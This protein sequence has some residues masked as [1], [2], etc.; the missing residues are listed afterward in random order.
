MPTAAKIGYYLRACAAL[1]RQPVNLQA[2]ARVAVG[3][4]AELR[5]PYDVRLTVLHPLDVLLA[6]ETVIDDHYG[7]RQLR[8]ARRIVDA[9]AGT[10][11]FSILAAKLFPA[12]E[13]VCFEP[14]PRYFEVL[15]RNLRRN[16]S[17]NVT[18]Y[19]VALGDGDGTRR[20]ADF[21]HA[22][23]DLLKI[24]CE[25]VELDILAGLG[26]E[27]LGLVRNVVLEYHDVFVPGQAGRLTD[28]LQAAGFRCR[29]EPNRYDPG[30]GYVFGARAR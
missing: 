10:G 3:A 25:G 6:T 19:D 4:P 15:G 16:G 18:A 28:L 8:D 11:D 9:G 24:D 22:E 26:P 13:I 21:V 29:T 27:K 5:L 12:A 23:I 7:L 1:L 14:D 17:R 30:I 2:L 20:L